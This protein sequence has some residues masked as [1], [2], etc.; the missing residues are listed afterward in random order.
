M[1]TTGLLPSDLPLHEHLRAHARATPDKAAYLWY[2]AR[3]TFAQVQS[4]G[5]G[6]LLLTFTA[7]V[8]T[9]LCGIVLARS[10]GLSRDLGVLSGGSVAICNGANSFAPAR[11]NSKNGA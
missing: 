6:A 7:V 3:I 10:A 4:L 8:L 11:N 9:I 1:T 2:G 5:S